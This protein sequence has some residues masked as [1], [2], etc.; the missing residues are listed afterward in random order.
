MTSQDIDPRTPI[1]VGVGQF[2]ER[3]DEPGYRRLSPVELAAEAA[4][5]AIADTAPTPRRW[6]RPSRSSRACVSSRSPFRV[7]PPR[8]ADPTTTRG[9]WPTGWARTRLARSL[10]CGRPGPQH[11]V[12]E[13]AAGIAAG[14]AEVVLLFGSEAI[15]TVRHLASADDRPDFGEKVGGDLE[16]RGF[17]LEVSS[18]DIPGGPRT[19]RHAEPVRPVRQRPPRA[20]QADPAGVRRRHGRAVRAVHRGRRR[21]PARRRPGRALRAGARHPDR[22]QPA[23]RRPLHPLPRGAGEGQPG[24]GRAAHVGR[25]G[26]AARR[27][28]GAVG[29]PARPCRPARTR[30]AGPRRPRARVPPRSWPSGTP[31]TW[32][33]S[34]STT[35]TPSTSTAASRSRCPTSATGSA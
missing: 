29:V 33:G 3:V 24:R 11:L 12:N 16:D 9:R 5:A 8:W 27:S 13:F 25:R 31:S 26:P 30:P 18:P 6:P 14:S 2:S 35:S 15:S 4:G 21:Q 17:G 20:A 32:R 28:R 34:A 1:L 10:R 22:E 19:G 7:C 23:H